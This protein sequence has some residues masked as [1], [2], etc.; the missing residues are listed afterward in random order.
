MAARSMKNPAENIC[1]VSITLLPSP[2]RYFSLLSNPLRSNH[3]RIFRRRW[4]DPS[5]ALRYHPVPSVP[6][7]YEVTIGVYFT[8]DG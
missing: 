3:W 5:Y 7:R 4:L 8:A 6:L 2:F 1:R